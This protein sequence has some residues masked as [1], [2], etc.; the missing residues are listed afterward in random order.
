MPPGPKA[1]F[2]AGPFCS[3]RPA[4][5]IT[6]ELPSRR[7]GLQDHPQNALAAK[8]PPSGSRLPPPGKTGTS[9]IRGVFGAWALVANSVLH[10]DNANRSNNTAEQPFGNPAF[11]CQKPR[12]RRRSMEPR[13]AMPPR[14]SK[15]CK[16]HREN[17]SQRALPRS[18]SKKP[19]R[20]YRQFQESGLIQRFQQGR[21]Q[22]TAT[23]ESA[24]S[25][26]QSS[27]CSRWGHR[28]K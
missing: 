9:G 25:L 16:P 14:P 17:F 21:L 11:P 20:L 23:A 1:I 12:Q 3:S 5:S 18:N 6:V 24:E 2:H 27:G 13:L 22:E 26:G 7:A 28:I 15:C 8:L 19:Y 10:F 4:S